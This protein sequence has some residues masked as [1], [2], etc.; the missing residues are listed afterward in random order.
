MHQFHKDLE[1]CT[2]PESL[3][4]QIANEELKRVAMCL[5][6]FLFSFREIRLWLVSQTL[7]ERWGGIMNY[8]LWVLGFMLHISIVFMKDCASSWGKMYGTRIHNS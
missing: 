7:V 6:L 8:K 2:K 3:L 1:F 4:P 5:D